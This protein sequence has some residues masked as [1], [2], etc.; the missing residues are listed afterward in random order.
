MQGDAGHVC[1]AQGTKRQMTIH[2]L[3][4]W[5]EFFAAICEGRK[6]HELRRADR[7]FKDG[8]I[9]LLREWKPSTEE[10]TGDW[11]KV[12]VTYITD[13]DEPCAFS[14]QVL[15]GEWVIMSTR[16]VDKHREPIAEQKDGGE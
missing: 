16:L 9:L 8:D 7:P 4:C 1:G 5:P 13:A 10:Y 14:E 2:E 11:A 15:H 6:S 3:K 12:L